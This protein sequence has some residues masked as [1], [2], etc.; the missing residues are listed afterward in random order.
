MIISLSKNVIN[1]SS[2]YRTGNFINYI[3]IFFL[4][5]IPKVFV[6][7]LARIDIMIIYE[8]A[9]SIRE[10]RGRKYHTVEEWGTGRGAALLRSTITY[11]AYERIIE[12]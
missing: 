5:S 3:F 10:R 7:V 8:N 12:I 6:Y 11:T 4:V 1:I 9:A 2:S